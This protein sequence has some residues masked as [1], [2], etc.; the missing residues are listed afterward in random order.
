[1]DYS[2]VG[3]CGKLTTLYATYR[4]QCNAAQ[5]HHNLLG[6]TFSTDTQFKLFI[7]HV[8]ALKLHGEQQRVDRREIFA[9]DVDANTLVILFGV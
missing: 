4:L 1:M 9:S 2:S 5:H 3:I 6:I 8:S 7:E